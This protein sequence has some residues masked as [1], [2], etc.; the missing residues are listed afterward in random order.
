MG[1]VRSRPLVGLE[2]TLDLHEDALAD[3]LK[4]CEVGVL[5]PLLDGDERR[6]AGGLA[7][8]LVGRA[9]ADCECEAHYGGLCEGSD[10]GL[11]G[12]EATDGGGVEVVGLAVV[13]GAVGVVSFHN[14]DDAKVN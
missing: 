13:G 14:Y 9:V 5:A 3:G 6:L 2:L 10:L 8:G 4:A 11:C 1:A 12:Y 7:G